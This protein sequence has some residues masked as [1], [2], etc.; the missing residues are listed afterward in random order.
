M[1]ASLKKVILCIAKIFSELNKQN[2]SQY[3]TNNNHILFFHIILYKLPIFFFS[4]I[5]LIGCNMI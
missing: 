1:I 2:S 3:F 5:F 4:F